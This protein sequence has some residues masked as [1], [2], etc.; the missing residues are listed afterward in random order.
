MRKEEGP[1]TI[2]NLFYILCEDIKEIDYLTALQTHRFIS[3][4]SR[5]KHN[6]G[7]ETI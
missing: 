4:I 7:Y 1:K 5:S 2:G 6:A 3:V